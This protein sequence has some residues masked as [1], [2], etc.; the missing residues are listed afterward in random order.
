MRIFIVVL[1]HGACGQFN[2][3]R[4][5]QARKAW[6]T[7]MAEAVLAQPLAEKPA[8]V[9]DGLVHPFDLHNDAGMSRDPHA[10]ILELMETTPPVFWSP[11]EG[12]QW[13]LRSHG[14]VYKAWRDTEL[15]SSQP[16]S[17]EQIAIM[18]AGRGAG[19]LDVPLPVPILLDPPTHGIYRAPLQKVFSPTAAMQM[20]A[21]VRALAVELIEAVRPAGACEWMH[22]V[23]EPLPVKV[24]LEL[25]GLPAENYPEYR[26]LVT[27]HMR[28][29]VP[30]PREGMKRLRRIADV[31]KPT[32]VERMAE[33]RDDLISLL[34][35][36][37]I[38]G[39]KTSIGDLENY[40]VLLFI[41]GLDTVVNGLGF[42]ARHLASDPELQARLRAEPRLIPEAAEEML[43]RYSFVSVPRTLRR[44]TVF[45]GVEMKAGDRVLLLVPAADL[46]AAAF[47]D[48]DSFDLARE[49]NVHIAF[50]LGPHR[51]LGS[52]LARVEL[53][54]VYEELLARLPEFRLDPERPPSFHGGNVIGV[55][56]LHLKW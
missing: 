38:E 22:D 21:K 39:R 26:R 2:P 40:G 48:P 52:H 29:S 51:C 24:F 42:G 46:D 31:M 3:S 32:I 34:L 13:V 43:R 20:Q 50:G 6:E 30:D 8:H 16:A 47:P 44:D 1:I 15:F 19:S 25:L 28:E 12:G 5:G 49:N 35:D 4:Q 14:A 27:E 17:D 56:S 7:T 9:P 11:C 41:A 36:T 10:R 55:D 33:P 37:E 18:L 23:A 45:E 53:Q 54:T